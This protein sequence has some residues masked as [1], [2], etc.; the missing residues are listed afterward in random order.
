MVVASRPLRA[1]S[2]LLTAGF[3]HAQQQPQA[4]PVP[5]D[6]APESAYIED[7][8]VSLQLY[9]WGAMQRPKV[10]KGAKSAVTDPANLDFPGK[11]HGAYGVMFSVPAGKQNSLRISYFRTDGTGNTT[12]PT[13]LGLF[14]I[15]Y[16]AGDVIYTKYKMQSVKAS[17]DF[18]SYTFHNNVRFKTLWGGQVAWFDTNT[19]APARTDIDTFATGKKLLVYPSLGVGF[20]QAVSSHFRWETYASGFAIPHRG[21]MGDVEGSVAL[22]LG[23]FEM[24]GG[25]KHFSVKTS[26]K[27]EFYFKQT[28]SGPYVGLR[29]YFEQ[30]K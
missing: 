18:L 10:L 15:G 3:V 16:N 8:G 13:A 7:G 20:E 21:T 5:K 24:L 27:D 14:G 2:V 28:L 29:W 23:K 1:L 11:T 26:P 25:Y 22:R 17:W 12:T 19:E 4:A 9:Y 30:M 6:P